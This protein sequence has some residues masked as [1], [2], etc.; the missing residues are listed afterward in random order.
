MDSLA[1][2]ISFVALQLADLCSAIVTFASILH[3]ANSVVVGTMDNGERKSIES[4]W[5]RVNSRVQRP[6]QISFS[7]QWVLVCPVNKLLALANAHIWYT[8]L[9]F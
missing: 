1:V 8:H 6:G 7:G 2:R 4:E 5:T 9:T 3:K